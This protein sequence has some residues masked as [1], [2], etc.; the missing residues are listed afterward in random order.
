MSPSSLRIAYLISRYPAISHTFILREVLELRRLGIE[1]GVTSINDVDRPASQL[2]AE[3]R[4]EAATVFYVKKAG[5]TGA[6]RAHVR[7]VLASPVRYFQGAWFALRL[8]GSDLRRIVMSLLYFAEAVMVG[9]WMRS[10]RFRHLHVHFATPAATVALIMTRTFPFTLSITVHGPDEFYDVPGYLLEEKIRGSR[11]L[12]TI[13]L[14]A[15]SQLMKISPASEWSKIEV[16]P[17]G[18][19]HGLFA[20]RSSCAAG[21]PFEIL[22]VGRLTPAKGQ[23]IL[24]SAVR[25]LHAE[26]RRVRL[27]LIGD[28]PDRTSLEQVVRDAG[29]AGHVI[30]EGSVNQDRIRDFYREADVFALASFAEGIPVVLMEAMAMEIPCVTTWITGIPELIRDSIDGLLVPPSDDIALAAAIAR[31]MDDPELRRRLGEAGRRR[32]IDKYD[33]RANV[34]KLAQVYR[35]HLAELAA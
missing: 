20:P 28:G 33:L 35:T 32:I 2:T 11:L 10:R 4:A 24:V 9:D 13:G 34:E 29:L 6:V 31:L 30:L 22:C 23:H 26:G 18:V 1:I 7:T 15:R 17:L 25:R 16:T 14:F 19:D 21:D 5:L 12:C 8:G 3:E 27:R